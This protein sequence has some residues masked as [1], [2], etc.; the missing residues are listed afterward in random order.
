LERGLNKDPRAVQINHKL[1]K[2]KS[3]LDDILL[4][5]TSVTVIRKEYEKYLDSLKGS[6]NSPSVNENIPIHRPKVYEELTKKGK[7]FYKLIE[8][9]IHS[10]RNEWSE[11]YKKRVRSVRTKIL[12]FEPDFVPGAISEHWWREFVSYCI[13]YLGNVN[14]T[15]NTDTKTLTHIMKEIGGYPDSLIDKLSW[16]YIEPEVQGLSWDKVIIVKSLDLS[17]Y[18]KATIEDSRKLWLA[19]AF[20]GRRWEEIS[21]A[22]KSNFYYKKRKLWYRNMGKGNKTI[23]IPLLPEAEQ[24]FKKINFQLP[25]LTNQTVNEDIKLICRAAGFK[26]KVLVITPIAPGKVMR[27]EKEEWQTVHF[28]TGR[29]SYAQHLAEKLAGRP[30]IEKDLSMLLGHAS[31]QTTWKYLNRSA[32]SIEVTFK[33]VFY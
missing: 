21:K 30:H 25:K 7:E 14:N 12:M 9:I 6:T 10:H 16:G 11:G 19:G 15:I 8:R 24:F 20:T 22:N 2:A 23:D 18:P 4:E 1:R 13:E 28:H 31:F 33:E 5:H 32:S 29:H 17:D 26:D 27:V 3:K